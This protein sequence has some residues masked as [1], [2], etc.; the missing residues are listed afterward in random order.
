MKNELKPSSS[1]SQPD[2]S[3]R[4]LALAPR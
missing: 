2:Y 1:S 3:D 4:L